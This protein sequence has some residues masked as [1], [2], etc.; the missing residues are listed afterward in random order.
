[1]DELVTMKQ[2]NDLD[3]PEEYKND[4]KK[5]AQ[6]LFMLIKDIGD[7]ID[8]NKDSINKIKNRSFWEKLTSDTSKDLANVVGEQNKSMSLF[9]DIIKNIIVLNFANFAFLSSVNNEL[10]NM[11]RNGFKD[12]NDKIIKLSKAGRE[13]ADEAFSLFDMSREILFRQKKTLRGVFIV[14]IINFAFSITAISLVV[15]ML[16]R[17]GL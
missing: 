12:A 17:K 6:H 15:L 5:V 14:T 10:K 4:P 8:G 9:L 11:T 1:M 2:Y 16:L 3:I 13:F 7:N